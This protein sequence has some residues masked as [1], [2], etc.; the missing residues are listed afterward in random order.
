VEPRPSCP[1]CAAGPGQ[2]EFVTDQVFGSRDRRSAFYHCR[3]CDIRF[4]HPG[5]TPEQEKKF[6]A[7]EF[8]AFM[9]RRAGPTGGWRSAEDHIRANEPN[10][11]RR[12]DYLRPLLPPGGKVLEVGCS[13]GFM[14]YPLMAAGHACA[15]V[16]PS[17]KFSEFIKQKGVRTF[18]SLDEVVRTDLR[19]TFDLVMHFFVLEHITDPKNFLCQQ[20][21]LLKPGGKLVFEV[22]NVADPLLVV[23]QIPA[24][25]RFYWSVAHPWYF[26]ELSLRH[27]LVSVGIPFEIRRDQRYDLSN[28]MVWARD[29][30]PGG[31]GKF[32]HLFGDD[33]DRQYKQTLMQGGLCDTLVG[34]L[35]KPN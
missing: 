31:M 9:E 21:D 20:L 2:Q 23:Y 33:L 13:S 1:L 35:R 30:K 3:A 34:I 11:V 19:A 22:P 7:E 4:Q 5:L 17:G 32:S 28:H 12:M 15:G 6:Y 24:F 27:L 10:R 16:E 25:D 29:G 14:L 18:S 26:S 8:E